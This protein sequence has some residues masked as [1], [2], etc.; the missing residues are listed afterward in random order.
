MV[1]AL[2][3]SEHWIGAIFDFGSSRD[4]GSCLKRMSSNKTIIRS[5]LI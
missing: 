2:R 1:F 3:V 5:C 4:A